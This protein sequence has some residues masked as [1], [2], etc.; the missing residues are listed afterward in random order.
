MSVNHIILFPGMILDIVF[1][2]ILFKGIII[3]NNVF[4]LQQN[5]KQK[6]T[7]HWC[8]LKENF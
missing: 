1:Y 8:L 2:I 6:V 5:G 4:E 7:Q 3:V